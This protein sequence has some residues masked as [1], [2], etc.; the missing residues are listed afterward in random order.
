MARTLF[1]SPSADARATGRRVILP[2]MRGVVGMWFPQTTAAHAIY[3]WL[4][5]GDAA[6]LGGTPTYSSGFFT[7]PNQSNYLQTTLADTVACTFYV[8]AKSGAAFS[9]S[10]TRPHFVGVWTSQGGGIAGSS[11][12]VSGTPSSAP[13]ATVAIGSARDVG[14]GVP[15]ISTAALTVANMSAWTLLVGVV[16]NGAT[17]DGRKIFDMTNGTSAATTPATGRVLA[18]TPNIRLGNQTSLE[19]GTCD[20]AAA[21]IANVDHTDAEVALNTVAIRRRMLAFNAIT[22]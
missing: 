11:V 4:D 15:G 19:Y 22:C 2:V 20:I 9:S 12:Y 6:T 14:A 21:V 18:T 13:A 3:N 5:G 10:S 7:S 16:K 8:V 17:A 1:R